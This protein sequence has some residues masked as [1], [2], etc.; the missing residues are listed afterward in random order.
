MM[1]MIPDTIKVQSASH[2]C[3][4]SPA[5]PRQFDVIS[6]DI[7][8][9]ICSTKNPNMMPIWNLRSVVNVISLQRATNDCSISLGSIPPSNHRYVKVQQSRW[10]PMIG[11]L[12][13]TPEWHQ[14]KKCVSSLALCHWHCIIIFE[15]YF[16]KTS[17]MFGSLCSPKRTN[18]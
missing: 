15:E 1:C 11:S 3:T 12:L 8:S 17:E 10:P 4:I 9:T 2:K 5:P 16:L 6:P 7:I 18:V 14:V 13:L